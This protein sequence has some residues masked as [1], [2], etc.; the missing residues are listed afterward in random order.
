VRV[1][2]REPDQAASFVQLINLMLN[3]W[4]TR[5]KTDETD[6]HV[7]IIE[8]KEQRDE[9]KAAEGFIV[10]SITW[11]VVQVAVGGATVLFEFYSISYYR[12]KKKL[13][14]LL[15]AKALSKDELNQRA[16]LIFHRSTW[17]RPPSSTQRKGRRIANRIAA[18]IAVAAFI[19]AIIINERFYPAPAILVG[20]SYL[21][22]L[23]GVV[24]S[25]YERDWT[26][27][28]IRR[29]VKTMVAL[30]GDQSGWD[31]MRKK[32]L[33]IANLERCAKAVERIPGYLGL[34]S[35][36][37]AL[38]VIY[39]RAA[40]KAAAIRDYKLWVTCP[41][42]FTFTDLSAELWDAVLK[43][44]NEK[45]YDL[46]EADVPPRAKRH[47]LRQILYV[48]GAVLLVGALIVVP[49]YKDKL[50]GDKVVNP[51]TGAIAIVL[52]A[53]LTQAGLTIKSISEGADAASK[54]VELGEPDKKKTE[55]GDK[56]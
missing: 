32:Q 14:G 2:F 46:R 7:V 21:A 1:T 45:W 19:A 40:K 3:S 25:Y 10:R 29:V 44:A 6:R 22:F 52:V 48:S 37:H 49:I 51:V 56:S 9:E 16:K 23:F 39:G 43:L 53:V 30:E 8:R 13:E 20:V 12:N 4:R 11:L 38:E 17:L 50:G 24:N 35:D 5:A 54:L 15:S 26:R 55:E 28:A 33:L 31:G 41:G 42:P 36:R 34:R 47:L 27:N 18:I